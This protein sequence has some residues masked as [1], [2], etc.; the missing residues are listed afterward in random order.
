MTITGLGAAAFTCLGGTA[1]LDRA[2][3][4][5]CLVAN[6]VYSFFLLRLLFI[7]GELHR[8]G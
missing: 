5:H 3:L 4:G 6:G 7:F 1:A 2:G 8:Q